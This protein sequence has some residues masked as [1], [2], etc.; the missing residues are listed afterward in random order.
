MSTMA[1]GYPFT[2]LPPAFQVMCY[3]EQQKP[4][5]CE[6]AN[7]IFWMTYQT[8]KD[9]FLL[10]S[11]R[12]SR[13]WLVQ[14]WERQIIWPWLRSDRTWSRGLAFWSNVWWHSCVPVYT[15]EYMYAF[16]VHYTYTLTFMSV[17]VIFWYLMW[18]NDIQTWQYYF[19][20]FVLNLPRNTPK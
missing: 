19:T 4:L 6:H 1:Q 10:I 15:H 9:V 11:D 7:L 3:N 20:I 18:F 8:S 12:Y 2:F 13:Q 14:R 17:N 16:H 5:Q